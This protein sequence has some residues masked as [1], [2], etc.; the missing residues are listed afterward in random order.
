LKIGSEKLGQPHP[1]L[2]FKDTVK[3][4]DDTSH[5][6]FRI[7]VR[8]G[9]G[10]HHLGHVF[11]DGPKEMGGKR[12]CINGAAIDFIPYEEMDEKGYSEFK[13]FVK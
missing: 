1:E 9:Q 12:Y 3:Y 6:M 5:N 10:D 2:N 11:N 13:K 7:E 4:L 8:S